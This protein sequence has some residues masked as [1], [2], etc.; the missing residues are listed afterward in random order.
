[1]YKLINEDGTLVKDYPAPEIY[2]TLSK[3][4]KE[5]IQIFKDEI[6]KFTL[7]EGLGRV[8]VHVSYEGPN[9]EKTFMIKNANGYTNEQYNKKI[10][11]IFHYLK[12]FSKEN[13]IY[14]FFLESY[15][16]LNEEI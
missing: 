3:K 11:E 15:I 5:N 14:N 7:K 10:N 4:E 1:M 16:L 12:K 6:E 2:K 8:S 9:L 13:N